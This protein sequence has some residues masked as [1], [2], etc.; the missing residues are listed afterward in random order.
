MINKYYSQQQ[1]IIYNLSY[2]DFIIQQEKRLIF[3]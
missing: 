1:E 2:S 3:T